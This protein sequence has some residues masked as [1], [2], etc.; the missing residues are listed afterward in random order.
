MATLEKFSKQNPILA[1]IL[2][3]FGI[4]WAVWFSVPLLAGPEWAAGKIVTG[5]GFGPALAAIILNKLRGDGG[6]F[7]TSKWWLSFAVVFTLVGVIDLS[8]LLTGDGITAAEFA[9]SQPPG[10]T[11]IGVISS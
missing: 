5:I 2:L 6:K 4:T 9:T 11:I 7:G 10:L 8:I 1:Y 3:C